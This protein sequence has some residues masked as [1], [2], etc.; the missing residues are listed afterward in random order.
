MVHAATAEG[1]RQDALSRAMEAVKNGPTP[2]RLLLEPSE[3]ESDENYFINDILSSA[4]DVRIYIWS[5]LILN[6]VF[7][8]NFI[9]FYLLP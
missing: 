9:I 5:I 7:K 3:P 2:A 8:A 6:L 4:D 1:L